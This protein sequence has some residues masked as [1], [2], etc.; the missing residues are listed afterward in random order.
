MDK[1]VENIED[2]IFVLKKRLREEEMREIYETR[3]K[4]IIEVSER[5]KNRKRLKEANQSNR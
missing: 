2:R 4:S 1:Y 5:I 3:F